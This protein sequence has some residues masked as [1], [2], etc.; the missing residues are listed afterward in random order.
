MPAA[1]SHAHFIKAQ[2]QIFLKETSHP[3]AKAAFYPDFAHEDNLYANSLSN[4]SFVF[5]LLGST[6]GTLIIVL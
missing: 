1:Y 2:K 6:C 3:E 5:P 4:K